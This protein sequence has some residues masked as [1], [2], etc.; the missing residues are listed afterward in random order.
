MFF[1]ATQE[2]TYLEAFP[3]NLWTRL[4]E[5]TGHGFEEGQQL[6]FTMTME[7]GANFSKPGADHFS[8]DRSKSSLGSAELSNFLH[9]VFRAFYTIPPYTA[10][11][12]SLV[13]PSIHFR[14][15][16]NK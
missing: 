10:G 16:V 11:I 9:P 6:L 15:P 13:S 14:S 3:V 5:M 4:Y 1:S 12:A 8:V 7:Y 2:F